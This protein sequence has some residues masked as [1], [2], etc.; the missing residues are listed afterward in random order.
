MRRDLWGTAML[1]QQTISDFESY[2]DA[3]PRFSD[4]PDLAYKPGLERIEALLGEMGRPQDAFDCIHIAGTNGKGS[5][6]SMIAA[7]GT[8]AGYRIG[9]HTSPHLF[10]VTE[11]MRINGRPVSGDRLWNAVGH[12]RGLA[13]QIRPS[14]FEFTL[15]LA[16]NFF[17]E[18]EVDFAVIEVG[19]GGRLD[20][21]NVLLPVLSVITDVG[22]DHM[23]HL[24][25]SI[26][27][28]AFEKAGIIKPGVPVVTS[29]RAASQVIEQVAANAGSDLHQTAAEVTFSSAVFDSQ[30]SRVTAETP[31]RVYEDLYIGLAGEH[32]LQ[33]AR[34]AL[35]A[36][37][38]VYNDVHVSERAVFDGMRNIRA[39]SGLRGRLEVLQTDP[40]IVADVA[41]NPAGIAAAVHYFNRIIGLSGR[42]HVLIGLMRDK[43]VEAIAREL[44]IADALVRPVTV[45]SERVLAPEELASRLEVFNVMTGPSCTV[46]QGVRDFIAEANFRDALLITGSHLVVSALETVSI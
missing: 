29:S 45:S 46:Q 30:G 39:L 24:G 38:L 27:A 10:H 15:A 19:M 28:I 23:D 1:D 11:R 6:A 37:E 16:V 44:S 33:N 26:E 5:T 32:Q 9:L 25:T 4:T 22:F 35:R 3:L 12:F 18:D 21:T 36:A 34:S 40:L 43:D 41:H 42:L 13:E 31:I 17:A 2:L 7:I 8:A 20:A 14:F